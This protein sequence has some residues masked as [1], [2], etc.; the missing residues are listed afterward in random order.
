[1]PQELYD[2]FAALGTQLGPPTRLFEPWLGG[3]RFTALQAFRRWVPDKTVTFM[4]VVHIGQADR[5]AAGM[6]GR[7]DAVTAGVVVNG[8]P[9]VS[10]E[11]LARMKRWWD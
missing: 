4:D 6:A 5:V 1:M 8:L 11:G 9:A 7:C 2:L 10:R 3:S